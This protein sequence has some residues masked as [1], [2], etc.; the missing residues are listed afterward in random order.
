MTRIWTQA[1]IISGLAL[2]VG[3]GILTCYVRERERVRETLALW[4]K[5][6]QNKTNKK[7]TQNVLFCKLLVPQINTTNLNLFL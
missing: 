1:D 4:D 2:I 5:P 7:S 3:G 6:K